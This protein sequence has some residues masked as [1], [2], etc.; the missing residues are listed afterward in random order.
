MHAARLDTNLRTLLVGPIA[1]AQFAALAHS[2]HESFKKSLPE[3]CLVSWR[4]S[5]GSAV[6]WNFVVRKGGTMTAVVG[7]RVPSCV[8]F[9]FFFFS[10][11]F[12]PFFFLFGFG[13]CDVILSP[14]LT[15]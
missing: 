6:A 9:F 10:I 2:G 1:T 3:Y 15:P 12:F 7:F 14:H 4:E 8:P 5:R 11:L 13:G